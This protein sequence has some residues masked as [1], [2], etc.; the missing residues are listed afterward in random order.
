MKL[1]PT[2]DKLDLRIL[3]PK[4][5]CAEHVAQ[6]WKG[7]PTDASLRTFAIK[8]SLAALIKKGDT[9][10]KE[11]FYIDL[12]KKVEEREPVV[13]FREFKGNISDLGPHYKNMKNGPIRFYDRFMTVDMKV[14]ST[15]YAKGSGAEAALF[16]SV[17]E[18]AIPSDDD[19][20]V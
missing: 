19:L 15:N 20:S 7:T 2:C 10:P 16:L 12:P 5:F 3:W 1:M 8:K 17:Y 9:R 14:P 6:G 4:T 11:D 18:D 13:G